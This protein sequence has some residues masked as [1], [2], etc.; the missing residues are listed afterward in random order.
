MDQD[1]QDRSIETASEE[2][3]E[4]LLKQSLGEP[5]HFNPGEQV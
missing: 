1:N 4:A 5:V 2:N 3:F